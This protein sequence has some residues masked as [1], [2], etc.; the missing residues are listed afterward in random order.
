MDIQKEWLEKL[1]KI[2]SEAQNDP[3]NWLQ[4]FYG[5]IESAEAML[6]HEESNDNSQEE[7]KVKK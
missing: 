7:E 2:S 1:L 3:D 6:D 5:Y 4:Y